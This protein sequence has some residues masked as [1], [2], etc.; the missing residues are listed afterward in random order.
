M[1]PAQPVLGVTLIVGSVF[2][3]SFGDALIKYNSA[4]FTAWQIFTLRSVMVLPILATLMMTLAP[5][6]SLFPKSPGWVGLRSAL[7]VLMWI[8]YYAALPLISLSAAAVAFYTAPLFMAL[9]SRPLTG[10]PVGLA[11]WLGIALGFLGV[12]IVL[13]PGGDTFSVAAL[14]PVLAAVLYALAAIITRARCADERPLVLAL[15]LNIGLLAAGL[16]ATLGLWLIQ[17]AAAGVTDHPF[18]FGPWAGMGGREWALMALLA[19]LM[20]AFGTGVAMAY[21]IAPAAVIGTFD[22]SYVLFAVVWGYVL[23]AERPDTVA[24]AGLALI[25]AAGILVAGRPYRRGL[26]PAS[27]ATGGE[28]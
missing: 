2:L 13:R 9:L 10:E 16:L 12:L 27:A 5:G 24:V 25:A 22:Y 8:A 26:R 11:R 17:P 7:L 1:R 21:Q 14:L 15:G 18:L 28:R 20:V 3:M 23:F 19:L 6:E 4:S